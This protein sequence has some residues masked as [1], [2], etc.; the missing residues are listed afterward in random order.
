MDVIPILSQAKALIQLA[1][2]DTAGAE[3]TVEN[4]ARQCPIVSQITSVAQLISGDTEG[5][6]ETQKQC[7]RF[8]GG[9]LDGTPVVGHVKGRVDTEQWLTWH[10]VA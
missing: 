3:R 5:A 8:L 9:A 7:G 2:G 4:F 10:F 6:K 1:T